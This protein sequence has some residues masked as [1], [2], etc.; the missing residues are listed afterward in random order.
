MP[1]CDSD[2]LSIGVNIT[3]QDISDE[4]TLDNYLQD[5]VDKLKEKYKIIEENIIDI[6][7]EESAASIL[8]EIKLDNTTM[9]QLFYIMKKNNE[10][11]LITYSTKADK[12]EENLSIFKDSIKTIQFISH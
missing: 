8:A 9:K 3:K 2:N 6:N 10:F 4:E 1:K 11:W 12:F 7:Q 5:E